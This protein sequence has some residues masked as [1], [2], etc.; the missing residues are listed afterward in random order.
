MYLTQ[1]T[2]LVLGMSVQVVAVQVA[3]VHSTLFPPAAAL[4]LHSAT[5]SYPPSRMFLLLHQLIEQSDGRRFEYTE[6][7]P[8]TSCSA[9]Q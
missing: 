7:A 1:R 5:S 4:S 9:V 8:R 6:K 3:E 2:Q